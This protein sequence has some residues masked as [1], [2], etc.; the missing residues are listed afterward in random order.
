[1]GKSLYIMCGPA[2]AGKTT[3]V[4][5]HA[6]PG[7]SAHISRDKVRFSM[8]GEDEKYF[9]KEVEVYAEFCRQINA[10]LDAP[11]VEEVWA[12]ATHLT[13][14]ARKKLLC[15]LK[16]KIEDLWIYVVVIMPDVETCIKQNNLRSGR[17]NVP[18]TVI[19]NMHASYQ[20]PWDDGVAY[21]EVYDEVRRNEYLCNK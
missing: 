2:G 4:R 9:S 17:A 13:A 14:S 15:N 12:D 11:W 5:E 8:V 7:V 6:T 21:E 16:H 19:R 18:E 3:Y 10:A 20:D 1:M